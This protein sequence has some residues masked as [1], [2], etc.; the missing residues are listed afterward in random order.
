MN[1]GR[2]SFLRCRRA[3]ERTRH[4]GRAG[5]TGGSLPRAR[6]RQG[7]RYPRGAGRPA[8][9]PDP[10]R[11]RQGSGRQ[12]VADLPDAGTAGRARLCHPAGRRRPL[13]ADD[14]A[15]PARQRLSAAAPAGGAGPA[16]DGCVF[17]RIAPVL[18][19]GRA[20]KRLRHRRG[21]GQPRRSLGIPRPGRRAARPV[22]DQFGS[23]AA[24]LPGPR[25]AGRDAGPMGHRRGRGR[26][27][28]HRGP[29]GAH[30]PQRPPRRP[31][32]PGGGRHRPQR[33][34]AGTARRRHGG[35]DLRLHRASGRSPGGLREA[36]LARLA[37]VARALSTDP[38]RPSPA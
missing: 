1:P 37:E 36:A 16:D 33:A 18:P 25:P 38:A 26:R 2:N 31:L 32:G 19:P 12:P 3:G 8:R 14:E 21:P 28:R 11:D 9:R 35:A 22:P 10:G 34:A 27:R 24:G 5:Q 15:V 30:P 7:A 29:A 23:D 20:G 4:G 6:A 17:P 13:C